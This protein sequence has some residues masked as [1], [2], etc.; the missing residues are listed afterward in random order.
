M[1]AAVVM[2]GVWSLMATFVPFVGLGIAARPAIVPVMVMFLL[3][4]SL[5]ERFRPVAS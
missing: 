5:F 4:G 1:S 3:A 2:L